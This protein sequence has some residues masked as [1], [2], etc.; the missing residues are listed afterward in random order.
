M[1]RINGGVYVVVCSRGRCGGGLSSAV[2]SVCLA[3]RFAG[4][5]VARLGLAACAGGRVGC[6]GGVDA[7]AL[8][9][10][11]AGAEFAAGRRAGGVPRWFC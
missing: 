9:V 8:S 7:L 3:G 5:A 2:Y 6:A 10:D 4:V 11:A 1:P